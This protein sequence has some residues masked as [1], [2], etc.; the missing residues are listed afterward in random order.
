MH[1]LLGNVGEVDLLETELQAA[2]NNNDGCVGFRGQPVSS[3]SRDLLVVVAQQFETVERRCPEA[4]QRR[5][6]AAVDDQPASRA[7]GRDI[8][9]RRRW[10][11]AMMA[12]VEEVEV[13]VAHQERATL[14]IGDVFL[15]IDADQTRAD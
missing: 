8:Y 9:R 4:C 15:K 13:V 14:R 1:R 6:V 10:S 2:T 12:D 3:E 11:A 7:S 5:R